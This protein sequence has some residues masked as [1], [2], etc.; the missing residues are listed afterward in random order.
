M[1]SPGELWEDMYTNSDCQKNHSFD[2]KYLF[3]FWGEVKKTG[4]FC[5]HQKPS[6]KIAEDLL[7]LVPKNSVPKEN[8]SMFFDKKTTLF[9]AKK[10]LLKK[11]FC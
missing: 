9:L 3:V 7:Q 5:P 11:H 2:K 4:V 1:K 8:T 6:K 10:N